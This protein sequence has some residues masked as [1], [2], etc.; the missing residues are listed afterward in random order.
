MPGRLSTFKYYLE[1]HIEVDGEH[2]KHLAYRMTALA[3]GNDER[4]WQEA[5]VAVADAL[6]A[7]IALWDAVMAALPA[8]GSLT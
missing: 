3:C 8:Q 4:R 2:H 6:E 1:R 7:R 5:A